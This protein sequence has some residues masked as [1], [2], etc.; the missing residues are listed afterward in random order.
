MLIERSILRSIGFRSPLKGDQLVK[1]SVR[2]RQFFCR[3]FVGGRSPIARAMI[4]AN[5]SSSSDTSPLDH[6]LTSKLPSK[7]SQPPIKMASRSKVDTGWT[8]PDT[9]IYYAKKY[10]QVLSSGPACALAVIAGVSHS[11]S[12]CEEP[13][14]TDPFSRL[15]LKTSRSECNRESSPPET[16]QN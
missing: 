2:P 3:Y 9:R 4:H 7:S 11:S 12:D 6:D 1:I 5:K 14:L 10:R 16:S 13:I 8:S 15:L